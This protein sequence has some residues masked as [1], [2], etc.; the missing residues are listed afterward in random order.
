MK[1]HLFFNSKMKFK[2]QSL[3]KSLSS[4]PDNKQTYK[5]IKPHEFVSGGRYHYRSRDT[6]DIHS[7]EDS[8]DTFLKYQSFRYLTR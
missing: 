5:P 7:S 2:F 4:E 1:T 6:F 8:I 3:A